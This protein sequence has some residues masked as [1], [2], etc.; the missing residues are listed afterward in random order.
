MCFTTTRTRKEETDE[1]FRRFFPRNERSPVC[2]LRRIHRLS[3]FVRRSAAL[4]LHPRPDGALCPRGTG[5]SATSFIRTSTRPTACAKS[6]W[7]ILRPAP[8][9]RTCRKSKPDRRRREDDG[10]T[11]LFAS[12]AEPAPQPEPETGPRPRH[13]GAACLCAQPRGKTDPAV[14]PLPL[15]A[16]CEKLGMDNFTLFCFACAIL[17]STQTNYASIF[18]ITNQNGSSPTPHRRICRPRLFR[19]ILC[20]DDGLR[21]DVARTGNAAARHRSADRQRHAVLDTDLPDKRLIDFLFGKHP[22]RIDESYDRFFT[23]PHR[24]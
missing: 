24:E 13:R 8:G 18:Q 16:L 15:H 4:C 12:L 17:S 7:P 14:T 19:R 20:H 23:T 11:D 3:V 9:A 1:P 5:A 22:E 21:R 6:T 2:K 10:L